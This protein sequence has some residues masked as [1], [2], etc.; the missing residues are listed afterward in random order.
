M[1]CRHSSP[2]QGRNP[3][4]NLMYLYELY[5]VNRLGIK[6]ANT[7]DVKDTEKVTAR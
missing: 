2:R 6:T 3:E 7:F 5:T 1:E 4:S